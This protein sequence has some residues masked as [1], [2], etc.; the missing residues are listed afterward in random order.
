M[1]IEYSKVFVDSR[2]TNADVGSSSTT[3]MDHGIT[4]RST[5]HVFKEIFRQKK[6]YLPPVETVPPNDQFNIASMWKLS[7][8]KRP[9]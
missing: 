6:Q 7:E 5:K 2:T 9:N 8:A 3:A 4:Y 1:Y